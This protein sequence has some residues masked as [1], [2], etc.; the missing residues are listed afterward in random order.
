MT[1]YG[2]E[3]LNVYAG[4]TVIRAESIVQGRGLDPGRL[5]NVQQSQRSVGLGFEDPVT[6]AVNAAKPIID[7]LGADAQRIELV[8][9]STESGVDYSK[10][11][12]SYVHGCLGLS[13]R[14]RFLEVK[15]A[16]Y[17]ATGTLQLVLG[18]LASGMSP[19]AKALLIATDVA[20]VDERAGFS[21]IS[22]GF[23]AVALLLGDQP[24][25]LRIDLGAFGLHSYETPDSA[26]P[27][28]TKDIADID[29]SLFA[30][31][32]CLSHSFAHYRERVEDADFVDSFGLLAMHTPFAGIVKAGH[33]KMM[34]E[35][36]RAFDP[37]RIE[38]DFMRRVAP[39]LSYPCRVGNLCSGS[40]YLALASAIE[41]RGAGDD[42]RIGLFAYGSGCS[43]EFF[44]GVAGPE[45][46]R[47]LAPF[48]IA[49]HLDRRTEIDF[50]TYTR[51]LRD[52]LQILVPVENRRI[53][54]AAYAP[55]VPVGRGPLLALEAI[56]GYYRKYTW[57]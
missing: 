14:C 48:G 28:P 10:S 55:Y 2:I 37:D 30:Y 34:R 11:L 54:I 46:R 15:Q 50:A 26:R 33:R 25:L 22:T 51:L 56:A 31:L 49:D 57:I 41:N 24:D 7:A 9:V 47:T 29:R 53:D 39:S 13:N 36:P 52:N 45:G 4:L 1:S 38:N 32:D 21:E 20:L 12:A 19:G 8:A 35:D 17:G 16:C 44:S 18:Y 5:A 23:G 43:S 6:N 3:K 42:V 27:T 40:L